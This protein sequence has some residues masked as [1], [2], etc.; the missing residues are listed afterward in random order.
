M[1]ENEG[2]RKYQCRWVQ[3]LNSKKIVAFLFVLKLEFFCNF[4]AS[5]IL[6]LKNAI[7]VSL[8]RNF[9]NALQRVNTNQ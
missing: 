3:D 2:C 5:V 9:E 4:K 6:Y 1:R 8:F 7:N